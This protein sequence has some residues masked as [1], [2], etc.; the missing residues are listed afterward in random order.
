M[1]PTVELCGQGPFHLE[2]LGLSGLVREV[3]E[4]LSV[5]I[6]EK[7]SIAYKLADE[8]PPVKADAAQIRQVLLNL[9][10][11]AEESIDA[12]GMITVATRATQLNE[13]RIS[14]LDGG[15]ELMPGHYVVL[16]VEDTG[17]G[18]DEDTISRV[19]DPFFTTK[20]AGRGLGLASTLGIIRLHGGALEIS[21]EPGMGTT[22]NVYLPA[23]EADQKASRK[24]DSA[25]SGVPG[26]VLL[27]DDE[28]AALKVASRVLS[29]SGF[30]VHSASSGGKALKLFQKLNNDL[31]AVLLDLT[32]PGMSGPETLTRM[33]EINSNVPIIVSS[34]YSNE[35]V[36]DQVAGFIQK[37]YRANQLLQTLRSAG[38]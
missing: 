14:G 26:E 12:Q 15:E 13:E 23:V 35:D 24:D 9:I 11:N 34:G 8:I 17:C 36:L 31:C 4:I 37:P 6:S 28:E 29:R 3:A 16:S 10:A 27:V 25:T 1:W 38:A 33:R 2:H 21:S 20:F 5:R 19:F 18:M 22:M 7:I 30:T 32:M